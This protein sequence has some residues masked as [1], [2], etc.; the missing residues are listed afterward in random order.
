MGEL[1][2]IK[3]D[4]VRRVAIIKTEKR[5]DNAER[6]VPLPEY[7]EI[8]RNWIVDPDSVQ[9]T[10]KSSTKRLVEKTKNPDY[11]KIHAHTFRHWYATDLYAKTRDI[12][13]VKERLGHT[14]LQSTLVYIQLVQSG[15]PRNEVKKVD[16]NDVEAMQELVKS[17]W[18]IAVQTAQFIIFK[19]PMWV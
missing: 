16:I 8:P 2:T 10:V 19:K 7:F 15:K 3:F 9:R 18:E 17:G 11:L 4:G 13:L 6:I 14:D 5:R 1:K 12:I